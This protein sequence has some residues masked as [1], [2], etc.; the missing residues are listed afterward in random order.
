MKDDLNKFFSKVRKTDEKEGVPSFEVMLPKARAKKTVYLI[1]I[2]IAAVILVLMLFTF[3][4]NE[5]G[6]S[7]ELLTENALIIEFSDESPET[8]FTNSD[9][10]GMDTWES[11]TA[12][13][14]DD[15]ADF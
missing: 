1:P 14:I 15:F 3:N 10:P 11:P 12:I 7:E 8:S 6:S 13:L 5:T 9:E 2:G 4:Q